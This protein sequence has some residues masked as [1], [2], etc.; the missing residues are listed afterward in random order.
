MRSASSKTAIYT[1][2][3]LQQD[4]LPLQNIP[5]LAIIR[6]RQ[7]LLAKEQALCHF[8]IGHHRVEYLKFHL[9]EHCPSTVTSCPHTVYRTL[10]SRFLPCKHKDET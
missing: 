2:P 8:N 3:L 4:F 9:V 10:W 5:I 7:A 1:A 6:N